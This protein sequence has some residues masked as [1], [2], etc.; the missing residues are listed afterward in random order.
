MRVMKRTGLVKNEAD[1]DSVIYKARELNPEFSGIIDFSCWEI[2]R[3]WCRPNS[4]N[5]RE[6][7]I[8]SDCKRVL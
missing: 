2:G 1:L 3:T 4:P 5:C 7:I 6:C 8:F